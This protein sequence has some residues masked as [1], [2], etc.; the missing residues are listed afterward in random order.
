MLD[1]NYNLEAPSTCF[2]C[3]EKAGVEQITFATLQALSEEGDDKARY[4]PHYISRHLCEDCIQDIKQNGDPIT[5]RGIPLM[6]WHVN[7]YNDGNRLFIAGLNKDGEEVVR[8]STNLP[9]EKCDTRAGQLFIKTWSE[10]SGL[11]E[12]LVSRV[13]IEPADYWAASGFVS[14]PRVTLT[15]RFREILGIDI[16]YLQAKTPA[17]AREILARK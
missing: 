9:H 6:F 12:H 13:L 2:R 5:W 4:F 10:N 3:R 8:I 1:L 15:N 14:V 17:E 11:Y 16:D 7:R